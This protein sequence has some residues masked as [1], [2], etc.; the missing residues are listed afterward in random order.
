[1][2]IEHNEN[3]DIHGNLI[4]EEWVEVPEPEAP[5]L[6]EFTID[7]LVEILKKRLESNE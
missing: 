5:T 6:S 2:P 3:W 1:M 7:E 4:S